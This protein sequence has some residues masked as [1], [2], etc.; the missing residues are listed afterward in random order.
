M[1][2]IGVATEPIRIVLAED[3][4]LMREGTRHILEQCSD[5]R[6]VGEAENGQEALE[7]IQRTQ[8]DVAILDIRMPKLNG[9]EVVR[10]M[11]EVSSNTRALMLTAYDDDD[12]I[13][14]LIEAG[15]LG[16]LLKT[17]RPNDVIDAVR[18]VNAGEP[19]LHPAIA[20]KV[21]RLWARR[22][23]AAKAQSGQGPGEDLSQR[24]WEVL[25][26]AANG[27]RNKAIADKLALSVRTVEGHFRSIFAK[28]GV[29]SRVEA[30][31]YALSHQMVTQE[32]QNKT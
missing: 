25:Q 15:A 9:I 29:S 8:P 3:H 7:L 14:A 22:R 10:R 6:V 18:Q 11:K 26:L 27:F 4:W 21:A 13:L 12:Y 2:D 30:V 20:M 23:D 1:A 19:V 28:L 16:Y 5:C 31:L 32:P 17:A 24:E